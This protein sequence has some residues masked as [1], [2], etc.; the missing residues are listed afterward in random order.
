MIKFALH[1][2]ITPKFSF[3]LGCIFTDASQKV[4]YVIDIPICIFNMFLK[5]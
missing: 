1:K 3:F 2:S 4:K 5:L